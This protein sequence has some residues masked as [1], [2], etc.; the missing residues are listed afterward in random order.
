MKPNPFFFRRKTLGS[1]FIAM[2]A[3]LQ[4]KIPV[5]GLLVV[6]W[7]AYFVTP[8]VYAKNM[9]VEGGSCDCGLK[10]SLSPQ[11]IQ[12]E[13]L[14]TRII[15]KKM[16]ASEKICDDFIG[17]TCGKIAPVD[18][19]G[20]VAPVMESATSKKI[21]QAD[22]QL[23]RRFQAEWNAKK[24]KKMKVQDYV[25]HRY[26]E[27]WEFVKK[28]DQADTVLTEVLDDVEVFFRPY[29]SFKDR[30]LL[31]QTRWL[32]ISRDY[33]SEPG[34]LF[35]NKLAISHQIQIGGVYLRTNTSHN[36]LYF[37]LA[38]EIGHHISDIADLFLPSVKKCI[39]ARYQ[40]LSFYLKKKVSL[41]E[42]WADWFAE[43]LFASRLKRIKSANKFSSAQ[44]AVRFFCD[45]GGSALGHPDGI[46]R[47][48][49]FLSHEEIQNE[50][51]PMD[52][53]VL[54]KACL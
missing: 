15:L 44:N 26:M 3:F 53:K 2:R 4:K 21:F 13:F 41:E 16:R 39:Q 20:T 22:T 19:T 1:R 27:E 23:L 29:L 9:S 11:F 50:V 46:F 14:K 18:G 42:I 43:R 7:V 12:K 17:K 34:L 40:K 51:C 35:E 30:P 36:S 33:H 52:D 31:N 25:I 5:R 48:K 45:Y 24:D 28:L 6:S 32:R 38:H 37:L 47:I 8:F 10:E 49:M 54:E